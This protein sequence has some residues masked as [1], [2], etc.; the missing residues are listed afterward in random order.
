MSKAACDARRGGQHVVLRDDGCRRFRSGDVSRGLGRAGRLNEWLAGK[1][2]SEALD[3][4]WNAVGVHLERETLTEFHEL[5]GVGSKDSAEI[6]K[7][8]EE[9]FEAP[10]GDDLEDSAWRVAPP[11]PRATTPVS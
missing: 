10:G 4:I 3:E 2:D 11:D 6:N 5:L 7:F 9:A 1:V 8:G